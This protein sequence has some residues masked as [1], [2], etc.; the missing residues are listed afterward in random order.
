[1]K[2]ILLLSLLS[3]LLMADEFVNLSDKLSNYS[4]ET[5]QATFKAIAK[6]SN[7]RCI[8]IPLPYVN[9]NKQL[10]KQNVK[11]FGCFV[12]TKTELAYL[13][14]NSQNQTMMF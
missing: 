4:E 5:L 14:A 2:K 3:S 7:G 13:I 10:T 8:F 1:M 9:Q 6:E 11:I 12:E